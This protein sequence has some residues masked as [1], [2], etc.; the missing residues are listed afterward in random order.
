MSE[1]NDAAPSVVIERT[2]D[3]PAA[4]VWRMWTEP[5]HF[6]AW[7]G[8]TGA[9]IVVAEMDVRVG[10]R[11]FV[12]ME[13]QTPNGAMQ[14]WFTGEHR[15]VAPTARLAY[16]ESIADEQGN[17]Q[18]PADMGMPPG[19]PEVTEV[20]VELD[21]L[22]DTTTMTMTHVGVPAGSPGAAGWNM[23]FDKLEAHLATAG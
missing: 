7:Y 22:G 1:S 11:R 17:V 23:A 10:G 2:L 6:K 4:L 19:H 21:D 3:A 20:V 16:T 18:S 8:P 14:M 12:G 9:T 15:E 5:E 13:M